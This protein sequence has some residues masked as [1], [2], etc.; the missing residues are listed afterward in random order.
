MG[1]GG[2][3]RGQVMVLA[4]PEG[5]NGAHGHSGEEL[6]LRWDIQSGLQLGPMNL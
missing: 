6:S 5:E 4:P 2:G 1:L 3:L